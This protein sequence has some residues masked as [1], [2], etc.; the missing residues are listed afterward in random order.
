MCRAT[1][2]YPKVS[3]SIHFCKRNAATKVHTILHRLAGSDVA[4]PITSN[5]LALTSGQRVIVPRH[6][7]PLAT[8]GG[9]IVTGQ[10]PP[11]H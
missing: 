9:G 4:D 7:V 6:L 2:S 8:A 3:R 1:I 11:K 10:T 5:G